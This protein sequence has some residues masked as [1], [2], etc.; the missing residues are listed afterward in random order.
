MVIKIIQLEPG[1]E[2]IKLEKKAESV[3]WKPIQP[4]KFELIMRDTLQHN[5][6]IEL[7]CSYMGG[8]TRAM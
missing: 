2:N 4:V 1:G 8:S 7:I 6:L 3:D 5:N